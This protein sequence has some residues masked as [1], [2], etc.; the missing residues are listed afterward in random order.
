MQNAFKFQPPAHVG[1]YKK[2]DSSNA[3]LGE[4]PIPPS[5]LFRGEFIVFGSIVTKP[6]EG[7]SSPVRYVE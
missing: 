3:L 1:S 5:A 2:R 7:E 4:S 6:E